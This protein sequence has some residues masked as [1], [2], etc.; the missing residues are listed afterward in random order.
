MPPVRERRPSVLPRTHVCCPGRVSAPLLGVPSSGPSRVFTTPPGPETPAFLCHNFSFRVTSLPLSSATPP[1]PR[2][3][4]SAASALKPL[5]C[6]T[7][8]A[9]TSNCAEV[10][11]DR[12]PA[13]AGGDF[14]RTATPNGGS[15]CFFFF[16]FFLPGRA[17]GGS[18]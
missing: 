15:R 6:S 8:Q 12:K 17:H 5:T 18:G 9:D 14:T 11:S 13:T 3:S 4:P 2:R 1:P 10:R 7:R 16:F